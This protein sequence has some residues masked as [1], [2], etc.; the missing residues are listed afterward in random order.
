MNL[1]RALLVTLV[2]SLLVVAC[3]DG[4]G[5]PVGGG[6]DAAADAPRDGQGQTGMLPTWMLEDIQPQSPRVGQTYGLDTFA[7]KVVVVTLLEGF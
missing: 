6:P 5:P 4:G 2:S 7:D 1:S 3:G